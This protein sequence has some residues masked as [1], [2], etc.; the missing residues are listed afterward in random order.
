MANIKRY[1]SNGEMSKANDI[2]L[3]FAL[4]TP[5]PIFPMLLG[6]LNFAGPSSIPS[7]FTS[8]AETFFRATTKFAVLMAKSSDGTRRPKNASLMLL[9]FSDAVFTNCRERNN[10]LYQLFFK[11]MINAYNGTYFVRTI[12]YFDSKC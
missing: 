9:S 10:V 11:S 4:M 2:L 6:S 1:E 8:S 3:T 12:L 7:P 5:P